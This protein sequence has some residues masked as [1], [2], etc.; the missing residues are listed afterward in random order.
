MSADSIYLAILGT[1]GGLFFASVIAALAWAAKSGQ[2][3]N[4]DNGA[5]VIFDE[6]EPEGTQQDFFPGDK[7]NPEHIRNKKDQ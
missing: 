3:K 2:L 6:D 1:M 7:R 4:F 5:K